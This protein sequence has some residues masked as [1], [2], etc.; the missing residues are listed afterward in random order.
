M[1]TA[2][3]P[4]QAAAW[5]PA[6][7]PGDPGSLAPKSDPSVLPGPIVIADKHNDRLVVLTRDVV[8]TPGRFP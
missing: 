7:A 6:A 1:P 5:P 8:D 4:R 2:P 3:D